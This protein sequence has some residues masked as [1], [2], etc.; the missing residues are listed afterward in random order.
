MV[1]NGITK[2]IVERVIKS[3]L[4]HEDGSNIW[5]YAEAVKTLNPTP[6]EPIA[7]YYTVKQ[8]G[9]YFYS[10][11]KDTLFPGT[12]ILSRKDLILK[13]PVKVGTQW[14]TTEGAY[15]RIVGIGEL[16]ILNK[17]YTNTVLVVCDNS[18]IIDSSWYSLDI[19]L[20]KRIF[21]TGIGT[22]YP[23]N[24]KWELRDYSLL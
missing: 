12:N 13:S 17:S 22:Q 16:K 5:G 15:Y 3:S 23:S 2:A 19:G 20:I 11:D 7:G 1:T 24:I 4:T 6:N 10:S 18:Q 9:L 8:D 14:E 21:N